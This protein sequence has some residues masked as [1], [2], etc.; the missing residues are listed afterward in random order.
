MT[1]SID[2]SWCVSPISTGSE[3]LPD[4]KERI[5]YFEQLRLDDD[6]LTTIS[7]SHPESDPSVHADS[8]LDSILLSDNIASTDLDSF[9]DLDL[10]EFD[11]RL[12]GKILENV[13]K[14]D[15]EIKSIKNDGI[16]INQHINQPMN[17]INS[18]PNNN[19]EWNDKKE[20]V[21]NELKARFGI[22]SETNIKPIIR[23]FDKPSMFS[24][25]NLKQP[26]TAPNINMIES[27]TGLPLFS[28]A[29]ASNDFVFFRAPGIILHSRPTII[30]ANSI[31][32]ES[33]I[34]VYF[35]IASDK[36][37]WY[38]L[39]SQTKLESI[40]GMSD[41][42]L[43][44]YI[45]SDVVTSRYRRTPFVIYNDEIVMAKILGRAVCI[46]K[47]KQTLRVVQCMDAIPVGECEIKFRNLKIQ[48]SCEIERDEWVRLMK[49]VCG[50]E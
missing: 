12:T 8:H 1:D 16:N 30:E 23:A 48:L 27:S 2:H 31:I 42:T 32:T 4:M 20:C 22:L 28:A 33:G 46:C 15:E 43:A 24:C 36:T 10:E 45:L 39:K 21:T 34:K 11:R 41:K 37:S 50:V 18:Q 38:I 14:T 40:N 17:Q 25:A 9:D 19:L 5:K 3:T 26:Q 44:R 47:E 6:H 49:E 29:Q 13:H 7:N 35:N